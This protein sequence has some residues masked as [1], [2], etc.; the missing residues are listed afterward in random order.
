MRLHMTWNYTIM[1]KRQS[2]NCSRCS[3]RTMLQ[4][5]M[6]KNRLRRESRMWQAEVRQEEE[7]EAEVVEV[8]THPDGVSASLSS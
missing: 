4:Y 6:Y 2:S 1:K 3:G 5:R 8:T 7:E